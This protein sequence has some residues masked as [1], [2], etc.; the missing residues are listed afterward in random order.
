MD[1]EYGGCGPEQRKAESAIVPIDT[2]TTLAAQMVVVTSFLQTMAINQGHLSQ[3]ATQAN[4]LTNTYNPGWRNHPNFSW[5]GNHD[6]GGQRNLQNSHLENRGNPPVVHHP[7]QSQGNFQSKQAHNQSSSSNTSSSTSSSEAL[8]KQYIEKNKAIVQSQ[9]S[10][11]RNEVQVGQLANKF[12]NRAPGTMPSSMEAPGPSSKEQCKAVTLRSGRKTVPMPSVPDALFQ[13][14]I[15][16]KMKDPGSFTLPFSIEGK[17]VRNAL[18][19]LRASINLMPLSIFKKLNID[20]AR[21]TT[22]TL[23][24]ADRSITHPKGKIEDVLVQVDKFI[25]PADFIILDYEV[26]TEVP[27]ILGCP[28]L[29]T[30]QALIDVQKRELTIRV[31]NQ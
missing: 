25:F 7:N 12:K 16:K 21:P 24:L 20:N 26:D 15:S 27:I 10:S 29:A 6:Q 31:N 5:G 1:D 17:E 8:L 30:E 3:S 18:Y 13:D 22:V 9:A 23:Q 2:M 11:I 4:A 14:N 28:F 19:D